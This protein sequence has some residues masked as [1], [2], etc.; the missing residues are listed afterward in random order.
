MMNCLWARQGCWKVWKV[1]PVSLESVECLCQEPF[2]KTIDT[3]LF[4]S[5]HF[6]LVSEVVIEFIGKFSSMNLTVR[7]GV[8]DE[9]LFFFLGSELG[10]PILPPTVEINRMSPR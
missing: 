7:C 6:I 8:I 3:H 1:G 9:Q 10:R 5:L 4:L 2:R